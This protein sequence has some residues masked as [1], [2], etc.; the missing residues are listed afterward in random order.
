MDSRGTPLVSPLTLSALHPRLHPRLVPASSLGESIRNI[1]N[2]EATNITPLVS[3][4]TLSALHPR[5]HPRLVPASSLGESIRNIRTNS[6]AANM[7]ITSSIMSPDSKALAQAEHDLKKSRAKGRM[8]QLE[9]E[10]LESEAENAR[11]IGGVFH[12]AVGLLLV[13]A[14][15]IRWDVRKLPFQ[16][17]GLVFPRLSCVAYVVLAV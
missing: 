13:F 6:E 5:L 11:R 16:I 10:F 1:T 2:S 14:Y 15:E 12:I 7:E 4:L 9:Q 3:P 8:L 17:G